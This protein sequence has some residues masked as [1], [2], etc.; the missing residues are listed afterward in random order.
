[1]IVIPTR[2]YWTSAEHEIVHS[3]TIGNIMRDELEPTKGIQRARKLPDPKLAALWESIV[4]EEAVKDRLVSQA[5]LNFK[6]RPV[7]YR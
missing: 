3:Q 7:V 2:F 1:M 5:M 4:I 6:L